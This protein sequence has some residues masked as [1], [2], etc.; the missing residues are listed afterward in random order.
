MSR[1]ALVFDGLWYSLCPSF[2]L[3]TL[4][5]P[6]PFLKKPR[7]PPVLSVA[8]TSPPRRC[9]KH[10]TGGFVDLNKVTD[11]TAPKTSKPKSFTDPEP[12]LP[13]NEALNHEEDTTSAPDS[14]AG[15]HSRSP[16]RRVP[17]NI[18]E[19]STDDLESML[20]AV[21]LKS[22]NIRHTSSILGV[23]I[24]DR[25]IKPTARH[26]KALILANTDSERGSPDMVRLLLDEMENNGIT[27]DSGTLHSAL[28]VLA[29]HPD[30]I[31][32]QEILG[33][34]R[35]RWL[36]LS[37]LGWHFVVAGL[38][39]EHQLELALEQLELMQRKDIFV[40]NWL[41]SIIIY[42][43]CDFQ[44][45]DEV[46]RLM[47]ERVNQNHDMTLSLWSHVLNEAS[48]A[49]HY[50]ATLFVWQRMVDLCYLHPSLSTCSN[51]LDLAAQVGSAELASSVF[52][53][54]TET[55]ILPRREDYDLLIKTYV[56]V[57]DL[58]AAFDVLCSMHDAEVTP[59]ESSTRPIAESMLQTRF[60][61]REAWQ[62][63]KRLQ[64]DHRR[65]IPLACVRTIAEVCEQRA[66]QDPTVVDEGI[67]FYKELYTLCPSGAD[68]TVY[69]SFIRMCRRGNNRQAGMFL[70]KEM[71]S[72]GVI[73]NATTFE[74]IILMCLDAGNFR[75]AFLYFQ[76][77]VKRDATV[78]KEA[79]A[80][81]CEICAKS[82][83][84]FALRLQYH[85]QL[86]EEEVQEQEQDHGLE[87]VENTKP[88]TQNA[89]SSRG[90]LQ[91]RSTG[92]PFLSPAEHRMGMSVEERR[93]WN[94][95]RRKERRRREAIA[96]HGEEEGWADWEAGGCDKGPA[97]DSVDR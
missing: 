10:K 97:K 16:S 66:E 8:A 80:E 68:V 91:A 12:S 76:D 56:K 43:L 7:R 3:S 52:R 14:T 32:R 23:L 4:S 49:S 69:N 18:C 63:L 39:R 90:R 72:L 59:E 6:A 81:I 19:K 60:D 86:R 28:Q 36:P 89:A 50:E 75:S 38:L 53:Y 61:H 85:P 51:V 94:K 65:N 22:P 84:E 73:P 70:V 9:Y 34:L 24:R 25:H 26:Y 41:H 87:H 37:P 45:F 29:V 15:E 30:Y 74:S 93:A 58:S 21:T 48:L 83:D 57:G 46:H 55:Q 71:A 35:D 40:E 88:D 47:Q 1:R 79:R 17:R 82:V 67:A 96:R 5:R 44:E 92:R 13:P 2:S 62:I 78:S 33:K 31:L 27:A 20:E 42:T 95:R 64:W 54:F 11:S 77:L